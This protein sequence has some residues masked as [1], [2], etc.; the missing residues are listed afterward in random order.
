MTSLDKGQ[1]L[2]LRN[3]RDLQDRPEPGNNDLFILIS[4]DSDN[5]PGN[6]PQTRTEMVIH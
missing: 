5:F 4:D 6:P 2:L 1:K 3:S